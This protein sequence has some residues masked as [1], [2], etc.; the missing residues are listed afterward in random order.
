MDSV[1]VEHYDL[2]DSTKFHFYFKD[3]LVDF[4][5]LKPLEFQSDGKTS[6]Y[7]L[8]V[9]RSFLPYRLIRRMPHQVT[10][11]TCT[12]IQTSQ[13]LDFEFNAIQQI[14]AHF[15]IEGF[16][17]GKQKAYELEGQPAPAWKLQEIQGDNIDLGE[18][19]HKVILLQFTGIG[20]GPCHASI[21]FLKQLG[22]DKKEADF[23]I[24]SI[25]TWSQNIAGMERYKDKNNIDYRFLVSTPQV[26]ENY[27]VESVPIFFLLD[28]NRV[29]NKVIVGY[30]KGVTDKTINDAIDRL[31]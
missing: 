7:E 12:D 21:P 24:L 27:K 19:K 26:S 31:L 22:R 11:E 25:E 8:V 9:D 3:K 10:W 16:K 4:V 1:T 20:C 5:G 23:E 15:K 13:Y 28:K 17:M 2:Q 30:Q 6:K 14:P 18:L 29:I